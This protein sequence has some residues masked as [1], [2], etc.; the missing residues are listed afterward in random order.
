MESQTPVMDNDG[1]EDELLQV[2][3]LNVRYPDNRC[4]ISLIG[5]IGLKP[6]TQ[7]ALSK[8]LSQ[9]E[10]AATD[11]RSGNFGPFS[12]IR[13]ADITTP[14]HEE[15]EPMICAEHVEFSPDNV[16]DYVSLELPIKSLE[17]TENE[18]TTF[19]P[20]S[21]DSPKAHHTASL[22]NNS[23][24]DSV[25]SIS[26]DIVLDEELLTELQIEQ[27]PIFNYLGSKWEA[28]RV[29]GEN[30]LEHDGDHSHTTSTDLTA[31]DDHSLVDLSI[32]TYHAESNLATPMSLSLNH[33]RPLSLFSN[34]TTAMLVHH[35]EQYSICLMQPVYHVQSPF[36]TIYFTTALQGCPDLN[37]ATN[38]G[39]VSI[40]STAVFHSILT[41]SAINL[42]GLKPDA[43]HLYQ[44]AYYH[45]QI[46]LSAARKALANKTSTYK[47]L[48]TAILSLVSVDVADGGT[49]D[50]WIHLEAARR[51][52]ESR[53]D[54]RLVT[55]E[56]RQLNSIC[57]M[58]NL[59]ART[60]LYNDDPQPWAQ[61][62]DSDDEP[63][64]AD[65]DPSIE[66]LYGITP[67]IARA[68]FKINQLSKSLAYYRHASED[69]PESLL[70]ECESLGDNLA[71]WT[72]ESEPLSSIRDQ[73]TLAPVMHAIAQ[74]QVS[75]FYNAALIY[76]F[77]A[78]QDCDRRSLREEQTA[79]LDALNRS[80]D[81][82]RGHGCTRTTTTGFAAPI[83]WPAFVASC[84][85]VGDQRRRWKKWWARVQSYR[86]GNYATQRDVV[87]KIWDALDAKANEGPNEHDDGSTQPKT[88][89]W[90][91][92][93]Y[94]MGVRIIPV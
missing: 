46:A 92:A 73:S 65:L 87:Y 15:P 28:T 20:K 43:G 51:L 81:L 63:K 58:L 37:M 66:F 14:F 48:M 31:F 2:G 86:V 83:S 25:Q 27:L 72:T 80:E 4:L 78:I 75:A 5:N 7:H 44:L 16:V 1:L 56:T 23:D 3:W 85:A 42:Q 38:G 79:C 13:L 50:H 55:H 60:A 36:K 54:S 17:E 41:S 52:Q 32:D 10:Q 57:T 93:L 89:D 21:S 59:F 77:R 26:G 53:H 61:I 70:A 29:I 30:E 33:E 39:E 69:I 82:K 74:A 12:V 67:S 62:P 94:E 34:S 88:M 90:R 35:Y 45:R 11:D 19:E 6:L 18:A 84:E 8:T 68:I 9:V 40:A 47:E 49:H 71:L 64:F 91:R 22:A 24:D 76:Y